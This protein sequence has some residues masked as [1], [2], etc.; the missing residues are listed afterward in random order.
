MNASIDRDTNK[1][2]FTIAHEITAATNAEYTINGIK[3]SSTSNK[4]E[5]IPCLTINLE[6]K[7]TE[8]IKITIEDSDIKESIDLIKK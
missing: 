4:I 7:T 1:K 3:D 2:V 6:K 5:T 8:P